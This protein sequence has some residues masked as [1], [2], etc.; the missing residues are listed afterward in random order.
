MLLIVNQC[1]PRF[2]FSLSL[3][4]FSVFISVHLWQ[5][6]IRIRANL[7]AFAAGLAAFEPRGEASPAPMGRGGRNLPFPVRDAFR[8]GMACAMRIELIKS[9][10]I[11]L[12]CVAILRRR[13]SI[14]VI[15]WRNLRNMRIKLTKSVSICPDI[16]GSV[17]NFLPT[18]MAYA[19][20]AWVSS[21]FIIS[22]LSY[23]N[24]SPKIRVN[25]CESVSKAI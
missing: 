21:W 9:V 2:I 24:F 14:R 1:N 10:L 22:Y 13:V 3:Y 25:L 19:I 15:S 11:R 23:M 17:S 6:F 20:G 7:P 4:L 18:G 12:P 5:L 8:Q 16:S